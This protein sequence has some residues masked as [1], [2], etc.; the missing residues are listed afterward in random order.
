MKKLSSGIFYR[1]TAVLLCGLST[2]KAHGATAESFNRLD[3]SQ[4][5]SLQANEF[6][7]HAM[8]KHGV[9][10]M[11]IAVINNGQVRYYG[12]LGQADKEKNSAVDEDT[13]FE[14]ASLSKPLFAYFVMGF[15]ESGKLNLDQPLWQYLPHPDLPLDKNAQTLTARMV[16][17]HTSGLPNWRGDLKDKKLRF[18]AKPGV[19]HTYSGEAFQYLA[20]VLAKIAKTDARGL[21]RHFQKRVL[22][23]LGMNQSHFFTPPAKRRH[24]AMPYQDGKRIALS[25]L[26]IEFGAAYAIETE[27]RD[28]AK[29]IIALMNRQNLKS[30]TFDQ[31]FKAQ[32]TLIP[33]DHPERALGLS[34]W[35]LG[36]S[37]YRTPDQ[38]EFF[39]HGGNNEGYTSLA[40]FSQNQRWGL[41]LFTNADQAKGFLLEVFGYFGAEPK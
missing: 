1:L 41:V 28:Y 7:Q 11:S 22:K 4:V 19:Q 21:N 14:G 5:T 2:Y 29:W 3:G 39:V 18:I 34:D 33:S 37:I 27:A 38:R 31:Y 10:G 8:Q 17:N 6:L 23:P 36:W 24:K 40:L 16:L 32:G 9:P 35:A 26:P 12:A 25:P 20:S 30:E 13:F 15:V